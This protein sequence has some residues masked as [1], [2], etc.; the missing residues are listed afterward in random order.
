M[1][2]TSARRVEREQR[3][4]QRRWTRRP[5]IAAPEGPGGTAN[6]VGSKPADR[7]I[8]LSLE[9]EERLSA[10][11]ISALLYRGPWARGH[12]W[13]WATTPDGWQLVVKKLASCDD[14]TAAYTLNAMQQQLAMADAVEWAES[15][16][17]DELAD[18]VRTLRRP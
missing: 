5:D 1:R 17:F 16:G 13:L 12:Y 18:H 15:K 2:G 4:L 10:K 6:E 9:F 7:E 3:R 11:I 14:K 8:E